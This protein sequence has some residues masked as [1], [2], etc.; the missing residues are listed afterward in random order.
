MEEVHFKKRSAIY[1]LFHSLFYLPFLHLSHGY[2]SFNQK[3][4]EQNVKLLDFL[5]N[6]SIHDLN[7]PFP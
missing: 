3:P 7:N 1:D 5:V 4:D 2:V 6:L